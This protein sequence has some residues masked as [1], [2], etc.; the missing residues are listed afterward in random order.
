M[1]EASTIG[2]S[3]SQ[4]QGD[5]ALGGY[6]LGFARID[7]RPIEDL[8]RYTMLYNREEWLQRQKQKERELAE[9]AKYTSLDLSTHIPKDAKILQQKFDELNDYV[10]NNPGSLDY[11]N[12]DQWLKYNKMRADL[13][14][15]IK[16]AKIRSITYEK[17]KE[18]IA[19]ETNE[20]NKKLLETQLQKNIDD[21]DIRTPLD[22]SQKYDLSVP[23]IPANGGV[24][25]D[26]TKAGSNEIFQR[27]FTIYDV[28]EGQRAGANLELFGT[29]I[30]E[31]GTFGGLLQANKMEENPWIQM[32]NRLNEA[33]A[34]AIDEHGNVDI[35]RLSGL[36]I[37]RNIRAY[38]EYMNFMR[39]AVSSGKFT[40]KFGNNLSFSNIPFSANDYQEI[41]ISDGL[42]AQELGMVASFSRWAGDAYDTKVIETD[43]AIQQGNLDAEWARIGLR[44][45]ELDNASSESKIGADAV[46]SAIQN[47]IKTG[48]RRSIEDVV[49]TEVKKGDKVISSKSDITKRGRVIEIAD[50]NLLNQYKSLDKEGRTTV[51]V[52]RFFYDPDKKTMSIVYFKKDDDGNTIMRNGAPVLR[53]EPIPVSVD[54]W[55]SNLVGSRYTGETK[56]HVNNIVSQVIN[57][58]HGYDL[59]DFA[60][61]YAGVSPTAQTKVETR[62]Q[63]RQE[64]PAVVDDSKL[65]DYQYYQ[66]YK[67]F[68][69]KK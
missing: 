55:I 35:N 37:I 8:A 9:I 45:E 10:R 27:N 7:T 22:W 47:A 63:A 69:Q 65:N 20:E 49:T 67:K 56:G 5:P 34:G 16:F 64:S 24:K 30:K 50:A 28:K 57:R 59:E 6:G 61:K 26:V 23:D 66:K 39:A 13:A 11:K 48:T 58:G 68:R 4:Y 53:D 43:N 54:D 38:N 21:T 46:L 29:Y 12:R 60:K 17:R 2:A 1:A 36:P 62:Q 41:N 32:K 40:D 14:N 25:I 31:K 33:I 18:D 44:R 42:S 3:F 52:D 19:S 15:D 51:P